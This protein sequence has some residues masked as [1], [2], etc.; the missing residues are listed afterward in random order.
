VEDELEELQCELED[1]LEEPLPGQ[2][3]GKT[4]Q[5][6]RRNPKQGVLPVLKY[7]VWDVDEWLS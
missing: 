1:K 3:E 5:H 4:P 7:L 6:R 2:E